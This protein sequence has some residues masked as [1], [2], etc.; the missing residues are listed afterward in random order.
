M[1]SPTSPVLPHQV[2]KLVVV[3]NNQSMI[4]HSWGYDSDI[5]DGLILTIGDVCDLTHQVVSADLLVPLRGAHQGLADQADV[6]LG[7]DTPAGW[8]W[9][10]EREGRERGQRERAGSEPDAAAHFLK[11]LNL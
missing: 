5:S 11:S 9:R 3:V 10:A 2:N 4:L 7:P 1:D 6:D 8:L